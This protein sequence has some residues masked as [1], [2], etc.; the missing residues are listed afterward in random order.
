MP[1]KIFFCYAR[2][3]RIFRDSLERHLEPWRRSGQ[4]ITWHDREILPGTKW[5]SEIDI[6]LQTSD[7]ILLLVS[8]NF[9]ASDYCYGVEMRQAL[10][11]HKAREAHI[12]P[13]ILHPVHWQETPLSDLQALPT[14]AK[15]VSTWPNHDEAYL[16]IATGIDKVVKTLLTNTH[17]DRELDSTQFHFSPAEVTKQAQVDNDK[18]LNRRRKKQILVVDDEPSAQRI[19]HRDLMLSGYDV[20]LAD[21]G[22]QALELLRLHRPDL[23]LLDLRMPG[24][25]D[26]FDVCMRV[27]ETSRVPIIVVSAVSKERLKVLALDL[28]AD[29]YLTKPFSKDELQARVRVCLRRATAMEIT[30][31]FEPDILSSGDGYLRMDVAQGQ[32]YAGAQEIPLTPTEFELLRQLML[33]SGK[34][35]TYRALLHAVW[36]PEY[37]EGMD[38]LRVYIRQLRKKVEED[39]SKPRYIVTEPGIG[40]VFF[41]LRDEISSC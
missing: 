39:P 1:V 4:I 13:I 12:I 33:Y 34:V 28:G 26:G 8:P 3:D 35:L 17:P 5:K 30:V 41:P 31:P 16:D 23:I 32:V 22:R 19:L 7:I 20:L 24:D 25:L 14:D 29:D 21:N 18:K 27:R 6:H 10:E 15:P 9:M 37:G 38:Y 11:K 40:Y 36:G 2:K